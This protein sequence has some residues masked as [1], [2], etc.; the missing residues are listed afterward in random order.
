ME[1]TTQRELVQNNITEE[2]MKLTLLL[3]TRMFDSNPSETAITPTPENIIIFIRD[4][5]STL[6]PFSSVPSLMLEDILEHF[7]L[8]NTQKELPDEMLI[9][10]FSPQRH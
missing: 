7:G 2:E 9:H 1:N 4:R 6:Q 8:K 3:F 5:A 10:N